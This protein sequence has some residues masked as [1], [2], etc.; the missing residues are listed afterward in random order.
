MKILNMKKII[1]ICFT[2]LLCSS[3]VSKKSIVYLND[4]SEN[5]STNNTYTPLIQK[6]DILYI[7]VTSA[8]PKAVE[9]YNLD[10][11][12]GG[13]L[14]ASEKFTYLVDSSGAI[15][16]A[17]L[18]LVNVANKTVNDVKNIIQNRLQE[19]VSDAVVNIRIMNFKVSVL[20]EV[21]KPGIVNVTGQR[22]TV[23]E[24]I[25]MCGDLTLYG[26]RDNILI[27]RESK[28]VKTTA[29]IDITKSDFINSDY[30]YLDQNDVIYVEP[31]K[32][33]INSTA[34]GANLLTVIQV[35]G[36]IASVVGFVI[37]TT[38]FINKQ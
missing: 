29:Y 27:M 3:C 33:K 4:I 12:I 19:F 13:Q 23:L 21:N 24:A 2:A 5:V 8:E 17:S 1:L 22:M 28:G 18:G 37:T 36:S 14:I 15:N 38:Y 9:P 32:K 7:K 34:I 11:S 26:K 25:A 20:G 10:T 6:D 16:F 35:V 31:N 30:Y